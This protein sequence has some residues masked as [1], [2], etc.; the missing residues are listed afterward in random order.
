MTSQRRQNR[1]PSA[2]HFLLSNACPP[3]VRCGA[4]RVSGREA[5]RDIALKCCATLGCWQGNTGVNA[6]P[7]P[8]RSPRHHR[9]H[10]EQGPNRSPPPHHGLPLLWP[11]SSGRK[12]KPQWRASSCGAKRPPAPAGRLANVPKISDSCA[13]GPP[14]RARAPPTASRSPPVLAVAHWPALLAP[15]NR[16]SHIANAHSQ[17]PC[18]PTPPHRSSSTQGPAPRH[19]SRTLSQPHSAAC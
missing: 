15:Y 6:I 10:Q 9:L 13:P 7:R 4:A 3:Q 5:V 8:E 11:L 2:I 16:E 14:V 1:A 18:A 12:R 17:T 19:R